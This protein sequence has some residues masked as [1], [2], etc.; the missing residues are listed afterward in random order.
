MFGKFGILCR[1]F[2]CDKIKYTTKIKEAAYG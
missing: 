1:C 2:R